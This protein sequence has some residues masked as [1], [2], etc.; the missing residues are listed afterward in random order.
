MEAKFIIVTL[1]YG[2]V[3]TALAKG[4]GGHH[5]KGDHH[6]DHDR[7]HRDHR[8]CPL[9]VTLPELNMQCTVTDDCRTITCSMI[10]EGE[11][12]ILTLKIKDSAQPMSADISLKVPSRGF[13]WSHTFTNGEKIKLPEIPLKIKH[14][15]SAEVYLMM[16]MYKMDKDIAFKLDVYLMP[17]ASSNGMTF[18]LVKGK[19][20]PPQR[21]YSGK[22]HRFASWFKRQPTGVKVTII[23]STVF[24]ISMLL[25]GVVY[26][27]KKRR[28][29]AKTVKVMPP[30][31]HQATS[32]QS[33]VP[34]EP[35]V[36][37]E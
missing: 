2:L 17:P 5:R 9:P 18:A 33:K 37:E 34:L 10:A 36:N 1:I 12:A 23:L 6:G 16:K 27:C 19:V 8:M 30:S 15:A 25:V 35:L 7:P 11:K 31:Y 29:D 24:V 22:C 4:G 14:L 20:P 32:I 26:C 21:K 28:R 13:E 3:T